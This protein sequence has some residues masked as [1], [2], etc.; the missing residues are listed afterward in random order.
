MKYPNGMTRPIS[1][2]VSRPSKATQV[3]GPRPKQTVYGKRG[4]TFESEINAT[5]EYYLSRGIAVIHKKP[6]PIQIVK[7]D[8]PAR[9]RAKI[10]EAYFRQASTTDYSGVYKGYYVDFEAKETQQKRSFPL[11][12]FH[13]HQ[14][15]HMEAVLAQGGFAFVLLHFQQLNRTFY[16]PSRALIDFYQ[17]V[18][19]KKSMSLDFIETEGYELPNQQLPTIPYLTIIDQLIGGKDNR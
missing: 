12:N 17:S 2:M 16:L 15:D 8:Y 10:T 6:T 11:K 4:M 19:G 5:N 18:D 3:S 7:V 1:K 13:Q 9:S 14:I